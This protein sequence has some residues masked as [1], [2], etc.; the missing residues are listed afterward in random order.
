M[1]DDKLDLLRK[2]PAVPLTITIHRDAGHWCL[3]AWYHGNTIHDA[4]HPVLVAERWLTHEQAPVN[5][6]WQV[7]YR[8]VAIAMEDLAAVDVTFIRADYTD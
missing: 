7:L 2:G 4:L 8:A 3:R 6:S 1:P 5:A